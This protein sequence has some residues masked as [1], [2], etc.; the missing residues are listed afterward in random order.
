MG[1]RSAL[2]DIANTEDD[3]LD[4]I[5]GALALA[6]WAEPSL[7]IAPYE[8]HVQSL[9]DDAVAYLHNDDPSAKLC[10][11][12]ARQII[13]RRYGYAGV[14]TPGDPG[15]QGDSANLSKVID[16]RR[17]G[18]PSLC[19]LYERVLSRLGVEVE[20]LDFPARLLIRIEDHSGVRL[21]LD[22]VDGGRTIDARGLRALYQ[23]HRG[24]DGSIDPF[25]LQPMSRRNVLV[26]L[27][28]HI[29]VHHLRQAAPEAALHALQA[30]LLIA[31]ENAR[32]WREA[33]LLHARLDHVGDAIMALQHFLDLPGDSAHRYTASQLLQQLQSREDKNPS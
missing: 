1:V 10:A 27:Q 29:K 32:L 14:L 8:R 3:A 16:K 30:A 6:A 31:P 13:N 20:V 15:E 33:G 19:L 2:I 4:L 18:A 23:Q 7:D 11:E 26:A 28:D 21:V 9:V 17:G 22:P 5:A 12:S 24:G 25:H